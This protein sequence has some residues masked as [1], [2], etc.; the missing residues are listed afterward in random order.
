MCGLTFAYDADSDSAAL[1]VAVRNATGQLEHRGPDERGF[2][3]GPGWAMGHTRLSIIDLAASH[4]PMADPSGRWRLAFNGEIYNYRAVRAAL[5]AQWQFRT[6]GDTETL[7]AGLVLEGPAFV[8]RL[9]GMWAFVLWDTVERRALMGRD[10]FGKK[11]LFYAL[12]GSRLSCAS[13]LPALLMLL[14]SV[15]AEDEHSTADFFRFGFQLP[16]HTAYR[17]VKEVPAGTHASWQ[18]GSNIT[19]RRYWSPRPDLPT[20]APGVAE[21]RDAIVTAVEQRLVADVE[22]GAFLSGG[23]DSSLVTAIITRELGR[24][25][26]TFSIGFSEES[27]DE[28]RYARIVADAMQTEHHELVLEHF[29]SD[30]LERLILR[31]VGQPFADPSLLPTAMVSELAAGHLKVVLSGDG[32]DE[33]FSGYQRYQ[34]RLL[35]DYYARLPRFARRMIESAI[36]MT[37]EPDTH[38]SRSLLKK[39]HLFRRAA[40]QFR[41]GNRYVAPTAF[42]AAELENLLP[43]ASRLGHE[44]TLPAA[45]EA[46]DPV[47]AM[48]RT[49]LLCY[50]PQDILA[51]VDRASMAY[52]LEVRAPFLD[53]RLAELA[54]ACDR[55]RHRRG[56]SGKRL[57][58]ETFADLLPTSI[59]RRRK[60]GFSVPVGHWFKGR[61]GDVLENQLRDIPS[62]VDK[63]AARTLLETHRRG[64]VDAGL[65]LWQV[66]VYLSWLATVRAT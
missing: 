18:P 41:A 38:H 62:P 12:A 63:T 5:E 25:L 49:D 35:L 17:G 20:K 56:L 8:D 22:V 2:S 13:E 59:W 3:H 30:Q 31:N 60:Q 23:I 10:R 11:P 14:P 21:L 24:P 65:K 53:S 57:L 32:A 66:H 54:L 29:D 48:M 7:L 50:L 58:R 47:R 9:E 15:P 26:K 55:A 45:L 64:M 44:P 1:E 43:G 40:A 34:A 33:M 16:G 36:G 6:N 51:K 19:A 37:S 52:G 27:Y 28:R 42:S 4:Q 46:D 39:A 61:L